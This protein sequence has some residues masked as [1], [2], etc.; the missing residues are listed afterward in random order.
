MEERRGAEEARGAA[1]GAAAGVGSRTREG[2]RGEGRSTQQFPLYSIQIY[3]WDFPLFFSHWCS[4]LVLFGQICCSDRANFLNV[5]KIKAS[6][7]IHLCIYLVDFHRFILTIEN[8]L[9]NFLNR[10]CCTTQRQYS[11]SLFKVYYFR[12]VFR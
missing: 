9:S 6:S 10:F 8:K 4:L 2:A 7:S 3:C 5:L 1:E 11:F 12:N